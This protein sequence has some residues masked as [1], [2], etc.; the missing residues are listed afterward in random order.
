[1]CTV[2]NA[3]SGIREIQGLAWRVIHRGIWVAC[4]GV[5]QA[6]IS[7]QEEPNT[8]IG[9][10]NRL[11]ERDAKIGD[12]SFVGMPFKGSSWDLGC[13]IPTRSGQY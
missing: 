7:R 9:R 4:L 3:Q 6:I 2:D 13:R 11:K 12:V 10:K 8:G 5:V 1:M